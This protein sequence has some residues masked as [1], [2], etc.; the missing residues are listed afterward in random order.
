LFDIVLELAVVE[1]YITPNEALLL[2]LSSSTYVTSV[3]EYPFSRSLLC[4]VQLMVALVRVTSDATK[5]LDIV[6]GNMELYAMMG[7]HQF[8]VNP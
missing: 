7:V 8:E 3:K 2:K 1:L 4:N 6:S 5:L